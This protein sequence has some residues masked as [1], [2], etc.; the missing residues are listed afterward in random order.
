LHPAIERDSDGYIISFSAESDQDSDVAFWED[1]V[2]KDG[3]LDKVIHKSW[4]WTLTTKYEYD[5][6][7]RM[8]SS[9]SIE[10]DMGSGAEIDETYEYIS[11]DEFGNWTER[12]VKVSMSSFDEDIDTGKN[13]YQKPIVSYRRDVRTILYH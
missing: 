12:I 8:L 2:W 10:S 11:T 3:L 6:N 9:K 1:L 7:G 4:E 5:D 13:T